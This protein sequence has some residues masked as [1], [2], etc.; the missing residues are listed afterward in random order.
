MDASI[1]SSELQSDLAGGG[2]PLVIDVR[3]SPAFH[4]ASDM[5]AGALRRDEVHTWNPAA[6]R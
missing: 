1:S 5:I 2:S 6:Y 3:K 4:A